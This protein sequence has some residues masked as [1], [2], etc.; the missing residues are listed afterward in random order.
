MSATTNKHPLGLPDK[1]MV[2]TIGYA[3]GNYITIPKENAWVL[4][5]FCEWVVMNKLENVKWIDC[6]DHFF[7]R[8]SRIHEAKNNL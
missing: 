5:Y 7:V 6:G 8:V 3:S 1:A 4:M 2:V